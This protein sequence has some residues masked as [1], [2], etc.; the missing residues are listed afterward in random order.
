MKN[1]LENKR[2]FFSQ[3]YGQ[4]ILRLEDGSTFFNSPQYWQE[5]DYLELTPLSSITDEDAIELAKM[6]AERFNVLRKS[7]SF[8][9]ERVKWSNIPVVSWR[10]I[11]KLQNIEYER[12]Y[13]TALFG[14]NWDIEKHGKIHEADFLRLKSYALSWNGVTVEDQILFGWI[15]LKE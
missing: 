2:K 10:Y 3:Y 7:T 1:T 9:V 13:S 11:E 5:N 14:G 4:F 15:K 6:N 8:K 12:S